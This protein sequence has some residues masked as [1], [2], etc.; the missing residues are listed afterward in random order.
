M[1][2]VFILLDIMVGV[3]GSIGVHTSCAPMEK[4]RRGNGMWEEMLTLPFSVIHLTLTPLLLFCLF[5]CCVF[6][7]GYFVLKRIQPEIL[8]FAFPD[9]AFLAVVGKAWQWKHYRLYNWRV[10]SLGLLRFGVYISAHM[11]IYA[12][13][14]VTRIIFNI[15]FCGTMSQRLQLVLISVATLA[16]RTFVFFFILI[17]VWMVLWLIDEWLING[18][19]V[20]P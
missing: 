14:K 12:A 15:E 5:V 3:W 10:E 2:Q 13:G 6:W 20:Q 18:I 1:S 9:P 7:G 19:H 4:A 17:C 8:L 11:H 16:L